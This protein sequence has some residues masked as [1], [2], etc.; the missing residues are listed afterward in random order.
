VGVERALGGR[1]SRRTRSTTASAYCCSI[2]PTS[3]TSAS[4]RVLWIENHQAAVVGDTLVDFGERL[5]IN[6]QWRIPDVTKEQVV[7]GLRPLLDLPVEHMLATHGR[8][9]DRADLER[10]LS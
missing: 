4:K 6:P 5:F 7:K 9:F 3:W 8:T 2:R 1:T 10:T